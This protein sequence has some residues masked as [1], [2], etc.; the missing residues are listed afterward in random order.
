MS[1]TAT[2]GPWFARL[3]RNEIPDDDSGPAVAL[4]MMFNETVLP[5]CQGRQPRRVLAQDQLGKR[6]SEAQLLS[7]HLPLDAVGEAYRWRDA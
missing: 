6:H 2:K 7:E 4:R 3:R 5:F 1:R